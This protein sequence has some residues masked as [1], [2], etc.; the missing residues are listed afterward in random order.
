MGYSL[1]QAAKAT[2]KDKSTISKA[3]KKG[4]ISAARRDDSSYDI[5][6]SE[7]HRVYPPV[8]DEQP[9][10]PVAHSK[11]STVGDPHSTVKVTELEAKLE[12]AKDREQLKDEMIAELRV[13]RDHW[14]QQATA[15]LTDQREKLPQKATEGRWRRAW[16]ILRGKS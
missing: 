3:I 14:R 2:G 12:A 10:Q 4:R 15:L 11:K 7:L 8:N 13:D 9:Q 16:S 6:P 1:S 5:D